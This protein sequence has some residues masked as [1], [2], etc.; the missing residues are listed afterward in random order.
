VKAKPIPLATIR[1]RI[2]VFFLCFREGLEKGGRRMGRKEEEG[3][4]RR[5]EEEGRGRRRKEEEGG[6]RRRW[7]S[8]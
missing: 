7:R 8:K 3:G 4:R 1:A 6:G 5:K 2:L